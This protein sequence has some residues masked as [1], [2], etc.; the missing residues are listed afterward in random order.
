MVGASEATRGSVAAGLITDTRLGDGGAEL[1]PWVPAGV[2]DGLEQAA[3]T[4]ATGTRT[5]R[6]REIMVCLRSV[7]HEAE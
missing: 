1:G 5:A 7:V 6:R 4:M 2:A 3:T